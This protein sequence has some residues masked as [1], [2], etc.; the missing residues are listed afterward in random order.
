MD[1]K[2]GNPESKGFALNFGVKNFS[3][4]ILVFTAGESPILVQDLGNR[5]G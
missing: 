2:T 4:S 5:F 1:D 3:L